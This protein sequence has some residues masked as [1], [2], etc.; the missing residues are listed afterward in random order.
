MLRDRI[1]ELVSLLKRED[2]SE[3]EV[4]SFWSTIR[5]ARSREAGVEGAAAPEPSEKETI[6]TAVDAAR[7]AQAAAAAVTE[8]AKDEPAPVPEAKSGDLPEDQPEAE[9]MEIVSPM[10]GTFYKASGPEAE[11][12]VKVG[13]HIEIGQVICII[14]A[15]K[16]MNEIES[17]ASGI[18]R[19]VLVKD[20][21]PV[22]FGQPLFLIE[23][24]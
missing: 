9:L 18:V 10:V 6:S 1:M 4:R 16:L 20:S 8:R 22:E 3:I 11:P 23:S 13:Q 14:E 7:P 24:A 15:M 21:Q 5:V 19:K 17:E 12:Y 2:L